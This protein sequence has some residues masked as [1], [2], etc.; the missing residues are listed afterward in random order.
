MSCRTGFLLGTSLAGALALSGLGISPA[1]ANDIIQGYDVNTAESRMNTLLD[2]L[3]APNV[4]PGMTLVTL[5]PEAR[6]S[7]E[8]LPSASDIG[9]LHHEAHEQCFLACSVKTEIVIA[10]H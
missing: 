3:F 2:H 5:R 8:R 9:R 4:P 6:F 1:G 7:G 10:G